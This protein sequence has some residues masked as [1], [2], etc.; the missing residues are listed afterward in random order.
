MH[1]CLLMRVAA[2]AHAL[3]RAAAAMR[4]RQGIRAVGVGGARAAHVIARHAT[5]G[6]GGTGGTCGIGGTGGTGS[7]LRFG[8]RIATKAAGGIARRADSAGGRALHVAHAGACGA[9]RALHAT[10]CVGTKTATGRAMHVTHAGAH[11][12]H[13][14]CAHTAHGACAHSTD[15]ACAESAAHAAGQAADST[16]AKARRETRCHRHQHEQARNRC[17]GSTRPQQP[18][19]SRIARDIC[20]P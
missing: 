19:P 16:A 5:G 20:D 8:R 11:S 12:A 3:M 6:T 1:V 15:G 4:A 9:R 14:A 18:Q 2:R 10:G 7:A 13:G 17:R